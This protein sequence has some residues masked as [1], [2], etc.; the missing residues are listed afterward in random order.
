MPKQDTINIAIYRD[1]RERLKHAK[2][3]LGMRNDADVVKWVFDRLAPNKKAFQNLDAINLEAQFAKL[4]DTK[5][6]DSFMERIR[7]I[8]REEI[9]GITK[10]T[11]DAATFVSFGETP[12]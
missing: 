9:T 2:E 11:N 5:L 6:G 1:D 3:A 7:E 4:R 12:A 8:V 10:D